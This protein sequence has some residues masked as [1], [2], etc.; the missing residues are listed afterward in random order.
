MATPKDR[1]GRLDIVARARSENAPWLSAL[2]RCR[3]EVGHA[4]RAGLAG[5]V[6]LFFEACQYLERSREPGR[7]LARPMEFSRTRNPSRPK[8]ASETQGKRARFKE[9]ADQQSADPRQGKGVNPF[10]L[11]ILSDRIRIRRA[12]PTSPRAPSDRSRST[13]GRYWMC[14][15][16]NHSKTPTARR[17]A[18]TLGLG[19]A[20][21]TT[22][23]DVPTA[24]R[25][26]GHVTSLHARARPRDEL[27]LTA[28][29][30]HDTTRLS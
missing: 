24:P 13:V 2:S 27:R 19:G 4:G 8:R 9:N 18:R 25:G 17:R 6:W 12:V 26:K 23:G 29:H 22:V 14:T 11:L 16:D 20:P 7:R 21:E 5:I 3:R 30:Q 10:P 28:R 15:M 1:P